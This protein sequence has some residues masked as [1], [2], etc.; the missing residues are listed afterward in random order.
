[1]PYVSEKWISGLIT[2]FNIIRKNIKKFKD[3]TEQKNSGKLEKYTKKERLDFDREIAKL[4]LK[5][6]G[7]VNLTKNPDALFIWDVKRENTALTEAMK[8][9][10]P[11]IA[12]CDTNI[13]PQGIDYIIPA[14]DDAS[15]GV[16]LLMNSV[17]E[18]IKDAKT[19]KN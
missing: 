12:V 1:M 5:V 4:N 8:K 7:L 18:A 9:K 2:N 19:N 10:I 11:I 16:K 15:K 17:N 13:N 14:N 3:L 6:G